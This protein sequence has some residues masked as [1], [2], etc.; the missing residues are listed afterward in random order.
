MDIARLRAE[1]GGAAAPD[2]GDAPLDRA[3]EQAIAARDAI[4]AAA[5]PALKAAAGA[6]PMALGRQPARRQAAERRPLLN[7]SVTAA[8]RRQTLKLC[9]Q[10]WASSR[11][12]RG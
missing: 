8:A 5:D 12:K 7:R 1:A 9:R 6:L 2:T 4:V 10:L 11:A 3:V